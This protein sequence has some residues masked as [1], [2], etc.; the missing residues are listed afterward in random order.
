LK[1]NSQFLLILLL[2]TIGLR[3]IHLSA[4]PPA[5]FDWSGGYFADE[6]Y[7]SH[8]AR[9]QVLFGSA[10]QDDWDARI[11][12]PIF[13]RLQNIIF[14]LTGV[15][16]LQVR[17]IGVLSAIVIAAAT[18][19][20]TRKHWDS[21]T[22][23]Y[24]AVVASLNFPMLVLARQG[25]PDSFAAALAWAALCLLFI[26]FAPAAFCAGVLLVSAFITKY[27]MIY[28]FIPVLA[29]F[30]WNRKSISG[31]RMWAFIEGLFLAIA[32]WLFLNYIPNQGTISAYNRFYSS[33][34]SQ[35]IWGIVPV[36]KNILMQPFFLYAVKTPTI[37]FLGN[38]M[39]WYIAIRFREMG[40]MEKGFWLWLVTGILFFAVWRYRP[41]RYYTSLIPPLAVLA[42]YAIIYR[43][44]VSQSFRAGRFRYLLWLGVAIPAL[45]ILFVVAD[46]WL[47]WHI[48]PDQLGIKTFDALIFILVSIFGTIF[49]IRNKT[50][51]IPALLVTGM[52]LSDGRNYLQWMI[53]PDHSALEISHDLQN[54]IPKAVIS[55]QWA[56][57][58]V[59]ENHLRAVPVWK[60]FVNS[61]HPFQR[62]RITHLLLWRYPLGDEFL[63]FS[64]WYP[65]DMK[66]F[67]PVK[68]YMIKNS[69]LI[70]YQRSDEKRE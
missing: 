60:D 27:F 1:Q 6:G 38:L 34:Q 33:Q 44:A 40:Q 20:L 14:I 49:L 16:L 59:L 10:V 3:I 58:L 55:G 66:N 21:G 11:V 35:Q 53:A 13:A 62:F 41:L 7:W 54:R 31:T 56:P 28:T 36:V 26:D 47:G 64:E 18:F 8:N 25:I 48:V 15:G 46:R 52:L 65:D 30:I 68:Q 61:D 32:V 24:F 51:W 9:N 42:C 39:I 45:Q 2:L 37:L 43:E 29:I 23:F 57:E 19:F 69:E 67:V 22:A 4:D 5:D 50:I 12:T 63:K 70:L 17:I